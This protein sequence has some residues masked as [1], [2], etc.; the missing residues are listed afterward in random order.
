MANYDRQWQF[1]MSNG[2]L[3]QPYLIIDIFKRLITTILGIGNTQ[4]LCTI[5]YI[6]IHNGEIMAKLTTERV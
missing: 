6:I 4:R 5:T 1:M 3:Q 2:Y